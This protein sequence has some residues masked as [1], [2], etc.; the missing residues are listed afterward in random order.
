MRKSSEEKFVSYSLELL[1]EQL[2]KKGI[3]LMNMADFK[4]I[5]LQIGKLYYDMKREEDLI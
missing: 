2:G 5:V 3:I 1:K 4:G